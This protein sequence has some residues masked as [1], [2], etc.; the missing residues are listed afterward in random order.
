MVYRPAPR[1]LIGEPGIPLLSN[2]L[3]GPGANRHPRVTPERKTTGQIL[4]I[5]TLL[6]GN[7]RELK[8]RTRHG[9]IGRERRAGETHLLRQHLVEP[10]TNTGQIIKGR[11]Q[12]GRDDHRRRANTHD[13]IIINGTINRN[14]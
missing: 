11:I 9:I 7:G 3:S 4:A 5:P 12:T 2:L 10:V 1:P 8:L 14:H 13:Q 6:L